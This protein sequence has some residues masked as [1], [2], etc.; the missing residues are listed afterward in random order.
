MTI[1]SLLMSSFGY[2]HKVG[3]KGELLIV[4]SKGS[5]DKNYFQ[6]IAFSCYIDSKGR[7]TY[8]REVTQILLAHVASL[9]SEV[10]MT[11]F[12][13][14]LCANKLAILHTDKS[15]QSILWCA[16]SPKTRL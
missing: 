1:E 6:R 7:L 14:T 16:R 8:Y 15:M 11:H 10:N 2:S 5:S 12:K 9:E 3:C 4:G 13:V